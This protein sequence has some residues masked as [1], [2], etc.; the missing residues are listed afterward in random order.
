M[1]AKD[2]KEERSWI[3]ALAEGDEPALSHFFKL[4]Q[5]SL[6]YFALRM[7]GDEAEA[8]DIVAGC[9]VKLWERRTDF[10]SAEKI[11]S[12]LY[13]SCRNAC[14]N[15]LRHLKVKSTSQDAYQQELEASS[16]DVL[17]KIV[18]S[19]VLQAMHREIELLPENYR[20][21][22][23]RIYFEQKKTDEIAAELGINVQ[24]VRNYKNRS[25]E[26]LKAA[27]LKQGLSAALTLALL[28]FKGRP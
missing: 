4:Y 21:V 12:F 2:L 27:M 18:E 24:T 16:E 10:E 8:E 9:F 17:Y 20:A 28:L 1:I 23:K 25:V 13:V 7:I 5:K 19:E 11:K 6:G 26:L 14:L 15:Y 3:E 22:F